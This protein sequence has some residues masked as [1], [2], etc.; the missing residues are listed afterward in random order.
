[1]PAFLCGAD[2]AVLSCNLFAEALWGRRPNPGLA[3]QWHGWDALFAAD[4][5]PLRG[6]DSPPAQSVARGAPLAT[7]I[8]FHQSGAGAMRATMHC[9]P[10]VDKDGATLGAVCAIS[11][12]GPADPSHA[13]E[14]ARFLSTLSHELR[15]PLSPIMSA[16]A[17]LRAK[18]NDPTAAKII[19]VL[20]RQSKQLARFVADLLDASRLHRAGEI[21]CVAS[22]TSLGAVLDAA[23]DPLGPTLLARRQS[24]SKNEFDRS[25]QLRCDPARVAQAVGNVLRNASA[26]SPDGTEIALRVHLD[27][28]KLLLVV[29]DS[30]AGIDPDF[31]EQAAEPFAQGAPAEGRAPSGAGL[32]LAIARSVCAAHGGSMTLCAGG[33]GRG[34]RVELRL[35][36]VERDA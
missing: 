8:M 7:D 5:A 13:E 17:L 32:G 28:G 29:E 23:L 25:A 21:P 12:D 2:G 33:P 4:G 36:I 35:P 15:N 18:P 9:R 24:L 26:H 6:A 22:E 16:A 1:M 20:D 27:A 11:I 14:R 10:V 3:G 34:A 31:V 30:G 19:E